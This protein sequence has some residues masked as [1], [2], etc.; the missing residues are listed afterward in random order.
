MVS[1]LSSVIKSTHQSFTV[2][3]RFHT[4]STTRQLRARPLEDIAPTLAEHD[5]RLVKPVAAA[6]AATAAAAAARG[7]ERRRQLLERLRG[8]GVER[9]ARAP[10][11]SPRAG[12]VSWLGLGLGLGLG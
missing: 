5:C 11:G 7:I 4:G 6:A 12:R 8:H 10:R 3:L 9:T 2:D 1:C